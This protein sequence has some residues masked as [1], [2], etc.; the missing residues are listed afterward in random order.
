MGRSTFNVP[1]G[2]IEEKV[3][4]YAVI[5]QYSGEQVLIA[6][7]A[8]KSGATECS[9]AMVKRGQ[10]VEPPQFEELQIN[11][12][13]TG[14]EAL[15]SRLLGI[16]ENTTDVAMEH[17]RVSFDANVKH[18]YYYL[19]QKQGF[20]ASKDQ[21]FYRQNEDHQPQAIRD[22]FPIL[23]GAASAE[24]FKLT[25][26]LRSLQR[27]FRINQKSLDQAKLDVE[28]STDRSIS[29]LSEARSVGV[30][31]D[32]AIDETSIIDLLQ[33]A[34]KW[35]PTP[36]P[37][38]DGIRIASIEDALVRLRE[39]RQGV[40]RQIDSA[41]KFSLR[42]SYFEFEV[43]EQR[44]RLA[45][46][47][48]LPGSRDGGWQWPFASEDL[49]LDTPI[50]QALLEELSSLDEEMK[51]IETEKPQLESYVIEKEAEIDRLS[52]AIMTKE[53]ELA[54]AFSANEQI[55]E[56]GNRNTAAARVVGRI[57]LFLENF[58]TDEELLRLERTQS[59]LENRIAAL[60][61]QI[62]R[63]DAQDRLLSVINGISSMISEYVTELGGEFGQF[64]ARLDLRNLTV[65][66]DRPDR[67]TY[68]ERTS[69]G[70]NHLAYHL[71]ALLALHRYAATGNHPI[72]RFLMIDQPSQVYFPSEEVYKSVGGSIEKT[73]SDADM[74][75]VRKLFRVL[76]D[77]TQE[78]VPGFQI[79]VT[80][81]ANLRDDWFQAALVESPWTKPPALVPEGWNGQ[82]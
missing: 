43:N 72:P 40:R 41:K 4:W 3:S 59:R 49:G 51:V 33:R 39:E 48:S 57:S 79:I 66:F 11:D 68:M 23:F 8:P 38:E 10:R 7:P 45:S 67:L 1:D 6:K 52:Q 44:D 70:E 73:E 32:E 36:V 13:D 81:H 65:V 31:R 35:R 80:E 29:L 74:E 20:V 64:P 27:Q 14:V 37:E 24:K 17:S 42:A 62:G 25:A 21:L 50:A 47:N 56:L 53:E 55:T 2:V 30:F 82:N 76:Y 16:P 69:G 19:F 77:Y 15:L 75:T 78:H 18:T 34:S 9:T 12:N 63:D 71:G 28:Q 5:Y 58:V 60:E 61:K 54:A 22:T 46:I 26:D